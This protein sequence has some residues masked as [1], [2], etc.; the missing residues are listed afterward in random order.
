MAPKRGTLVSDK[1]LAKFTVIKD[2]IA[3]RIDRVL[4]ASML[5]LCERQV[6]RLARKIEAKGLLGVLHGNAGRVPH[7][8]SSMIEER[9]ATDSVS[10]EFYDC[11]TTHAHEKVKQAGLTTKSYSTFRRWCRKRGIAKKTYRRRGTQRSARTRVPSEGLLIQ[12]DGSHHAWNGTDTWVLIGGIDDATSKV[13]GAEFCHAESTLDCLRVFRQIVETHG[14]PSCVYTDKAGVYGGAKRVNFCEFER[15]LE[16][17]GTRIIY[18]NSP[19][20]K[21]RIERLWNTFQDRLIPELRLAKCKTMTEANAFL[22]KTFI[23]EW[24]NVRHSVTPQISQTSWRPSPGQAILDELFVLIETR[25][26]GNDLTV[27]IDGVKWQVSSEV[28]GLLAAGGQIELR[29]DLQRRTE[30]FCQGQKVAMKKAPRAQK[31]A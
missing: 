27:S 24:F 29:T 6:S 9:R 28:D 30:P 2:F 18:A 25:K 31:S 7:N 14:V 5:G 15:V 22:K 10:R 12:W 13:V 26:L 1:D 11:N 23:P 19:Q 8:R 3:G 16:R 20:A 4:A 21:G 17:L